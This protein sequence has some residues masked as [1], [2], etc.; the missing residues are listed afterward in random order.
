[1]A[2]HIDFEV[3]ALSDY[4]LGEVAKLCGLLT[5]T[6][7]EKRFELGVDFT[8]A[9]T[10][11]KVKLYKGARGSRIY[12]QDLPSLAEGK[13]VQLDPQCRRK[14]SW[15]TWDESRLEAWLDSLY[16]FFAGSMFVGLP[17]ELLAVD[18]YGWHEPDNKDDINADGKVDAVDAA[19]WRQR[20]E[21]VVALTA[22]HP[23]VRYV[24][25]NLTTWYLKNG[26]DPLAYWVDGFNIFTCDRYAHLG[27]PTATTWPTPSEMFDRTADTA[28]NLG[29]QAEIL[30][31]GD[32][33]GK[34]GDIARAPSTIRAQW[35][36]DCIR[37]FYDS[38][39]FVSANWWDIGADQLGGEELVTML[40]ALQ[41][42]Q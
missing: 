3:V 12:G 40:T 28:F 26:G 33:G 30:E 18:L 7:P 10:P 32:A 31:W 14:V 29:V 17:P 24:G 9:T 11:A 36:R 4:Q 16:E 39:V 5:V 42:Q 38:E 37:Y 6:L 23:H 15:K 19:V 35:I 8:P 21:R 2:K 25:P 1:M 41:V 22:G 13:M 27:N 34:P 20:M